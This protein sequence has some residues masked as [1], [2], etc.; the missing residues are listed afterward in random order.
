MV[1]ELTDL[2]KIQVA[3]ADVGSEYERLGA[4]LRLRGQRQGDALEL[5]RK[6]RREA[7]ELGCWLG[8]REHSFTATTGTA[9]SPSRPEVVRAQAQDNKVW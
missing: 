3:L 1:L 9:I 4:E 6:A 5:R 2:T 7:Q 8:E